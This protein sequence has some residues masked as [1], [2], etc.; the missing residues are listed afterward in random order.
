VLIPAWFAG[1]YRNLELAPQHYPG[2]TVR[3]YHDDSIEEGHLL[4]YRRM[5]AETILKVRT[6][7][8]S[9]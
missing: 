2:W 3:I 8:A 4:T 5:G 9:A 6:L 1:M 7:T